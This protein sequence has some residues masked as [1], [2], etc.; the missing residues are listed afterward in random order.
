M[1]A[2]QVSRLNLYGPLNGISFFRSHLSYIFWPVIAF[3]FTIV[4]L[5]AVFYA[6]VCLSVLSISPF[7]CSVSSS[8][9]CHILP[10]VPCACNS[11]S[12]SPPFYIL[13]KPQTLISNITPV[14][15]ILSP[16][17]IDFSAQ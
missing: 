12:F 1:P 13:T 3:L 14:N 17:P 4:L 10:I 11:L 9:L 16:N 8:L 2:H 7:T 5:I 15:L 6:S